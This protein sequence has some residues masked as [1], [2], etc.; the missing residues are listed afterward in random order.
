MYAHQKS[1]QI[2]HAISN[3]SDSPLPGAAEQQAGDGLFQVIT[4]VDGRSEGTGE[5]AVDVG[6]GGQRSQLLLFLR[7]D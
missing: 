6:G 4:A 7:G 2:L 1:I 5:G 3:G